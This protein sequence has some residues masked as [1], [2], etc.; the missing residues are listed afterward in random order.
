MNLPVFGLTLCRSAGIMIAA[1]VF[2]S[3]SLPMRVKAAF[4]VLITA[5]MYPI[6]MSHNPTLPQSAFQYVPVIMTELGLG[7]ILGLVAGLVL[8]SLNIAGAMIAQQAGLAMARVAA[9]DSRISS[10]AVSVFFGM[11]GLLLFLSV[12]GHHWFIESLAIS[13]R[14]VPIGKAHWNAGATD[15][16]S[17]GFS[18]M[19]LLALRIAAPVMG[20]MFMLNVLLGLIAKTVPEMNILMIGY[21][22]KIAVGLSA[23]VMTFPFVWPVLSVAFRDLR[24]QMTLLARLI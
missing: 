4:A 21:P 10:T 16:I 23:M 8:A 12:D 13:F 11:F 24:I 18:R 14:D 5:L 20:V 7:L 17:G 9:P 22:I 15:A 19:F 1:P 2:S 6:A 3:A